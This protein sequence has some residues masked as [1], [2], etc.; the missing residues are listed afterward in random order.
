LSIYIDNSFKNA[1]KICENYLNYPVLSWR[2][3]FYQIINLITEVDSELEPSAVEKR[4]EL[5]EELKR[6]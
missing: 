1:R 4:T 6:Q 3:L 5:E 2:T